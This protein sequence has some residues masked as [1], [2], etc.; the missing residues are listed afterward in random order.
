MKFRTVAVVVLLLVAVVA[1]YFVAAANGLPTRTFST[2]TALAGTVQTTFTYSAELRPNTLFSENPV[3]PSAGDLFPALVLSIDFAY[4]F[5]LSVSPASNISVNPAASLVASAP[6]WNLTLNATHAP[7]AVSDSVGGVTASESVDLNMTAALRTFA[8]IENETQYPPTWIDLDFASNVFYV[9]AGGGQSVG[10]VFAP[11]YDLRMYAD[12]I[13]PGNRTFTSSWSANATAAAPNG[14][15]G[16]DL[17]AAVAGLSLAVLGILLLSYLELRP[18]PGPAA[19]IDEETRLDREVGP[20]REAVAETM[21]LPHK[22]NIVVMREFIDVVRAADMLGKPILHLRNDAEGQVR[23]LFY[24]VD[25]AVQ[26]VYLRGVAP[27]ATAASPPTK[28][29]RRRPIEELTRL[30]RE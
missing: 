22:E 10:H 19:P 2:T 5:T 25:G 3:G 27:T 30:L 26:Y 15:R 12:E 11:V 17:A 23:H 1:G 14:A 29:R 16:T 9:V 7:L 21:S 20:Y 8:S 18:R 6:A 24:V 13:V 4:T 28:P